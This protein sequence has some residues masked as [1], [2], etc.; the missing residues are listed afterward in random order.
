MSNYN[1]DQS[2]WIHRAGP[3]L[4]GDSV[5]GLTDYSGI[6]ILGHFLDIFDLKGVSDIKVKAWCK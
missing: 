1:F 4:A 5:L 2:T 3:V 6:S